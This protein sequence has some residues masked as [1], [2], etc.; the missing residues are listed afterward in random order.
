[1][2]IRRLLAPAALGA[3][4]LIAVVAAPST[5]F[6]ANP[7]SG[8]PPT[9]PEVASASAGANWLAGQLSPQGFIPSTGDPAAP[10]LSAT[11][12]SVLA[13]A[14][15][16]DIAAATEALDYLAAHVDDFVTVGASDGPGQLALLILGAHALG[17]DPTTFGGTNLVARLLA[18]RQT[19]GPDAGLFGVQDATYDGAYRQGLALS[20]LAAVGVTGPAE[21]GSAEQW[22][23]TQ[24]CPDGGWT[25]F[26]AADNPCDG[27]PADYVGPDTN[28]TAQAIQGLSAEGALTAKSARLALKFIKGAQDPDGG[29]GYEPNAADAPGSTDPDSTALVIQAVL[30]LGKSP[31]AAI[32]DLGS[33]NPVS[34]LLSFQLTSGSGAGAFYY[35]GSTAADTIATYQAVPA[36]AGVDVPFDLTVTTKSLPAATVRVPYSFPLSA[37]GS[38]S[39]YVWKVIAGSGALPSGLRLN[40][41]TGVIS[42]KPK[43]SGTSSFAVEVWATPTGT[44]PSTRSISWRAFSITTS[45]APG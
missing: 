8:I 17:I 10:D 35:P 33:A 4:L 11:A 7:S 28:S 25:S 12:N 45:P 26:I 40:R 6:S 31:S 1:M 38:R 3:S 41:T 42:G 27:D 21:V 13:L 16:G 14:G 36:L 30:A 20:A 19:S 9:V 37:S 2:S 32:F 15:A 39:P 29:W 44:T 5:A 34:A 18:T 24:Q 23:E 43:V 22:L